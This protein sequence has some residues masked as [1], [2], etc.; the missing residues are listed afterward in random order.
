MIIKQA[1]TTSEI[2]AIRTLFRQYE[3]LLAVD[4]CFQRF[5]E[6]LSSLPGKYSLPEGDLLIAFDGEKAVGCVAVRKLNDGVCEMKRL[7]VKPEA[8]RNGLGR[9]LATQII[10][11]ARELGYEMMRLDTLVKLTEALDLYQTLGF[12]KTAPYYEN[13]LPGVIYLEL[14]LKR[15]STD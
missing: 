13:P 6:E 14:D 8:R 7:F 10:A 2:E 3:E 12:R 9:K 15:A 4:L 1:Q 11:I 5:E